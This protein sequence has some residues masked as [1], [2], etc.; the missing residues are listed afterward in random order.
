MSGAATWSR[1]CPRVRLPSV[2]K[3]TASIQKTRGTALIPRRPYSINN[4]SA[5]VN[6]RK[7]AGA[8]LLLLHRFIIHC[9]GFMQKLYITWLILI[10]IN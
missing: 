6:L 10:F 5:P 2:V 8:G 9:G 4:S 3:E 1:N 7:R